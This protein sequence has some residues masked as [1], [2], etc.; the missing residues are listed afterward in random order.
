MAPS[1]LFVQ[2]P[3]RSVGALLQWTSRRFTP[4]LSTDHPQLKG[5]VSR[6]L[7]LATNPYLARVFSILALRG[8]WLP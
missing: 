6:V 3:A 5:V 7:A 4:T 8:S 2:D 1:A